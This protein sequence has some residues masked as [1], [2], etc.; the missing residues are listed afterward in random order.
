MKTLF[1]GIFIIIGIFTAIGVLV[2]EM[3][4]INRVQQSEI[5]ALRE[6]NKAEKDSLTNAL[7]TTRDSLQIAFETIHQAAKERQEA[8]ER[9]Q[10]I[11]KNYE[12]IIFIRYTSDSAR[13]RKLSE[14]FPT[15]VIP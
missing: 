5:D 10:R 13:H 2:T 7:M 8:H 3:R 14:L 11:I 9:T 1:V 6:R 15:Y 12:K 4:T